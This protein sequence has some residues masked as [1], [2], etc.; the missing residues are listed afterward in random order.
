M[1]I[2]GGRKKNGMFSLNTRTAAKYYCRFFFFKTYCSGVFFLYY[3][4]CMEFIVIAGLIF[5]NGVFSMSEMAFISARQSRLADEAEKGNGFARSALDFIQNPDVFLSTIQVG[6]TL[7][8][9]IIGLYSGDV[10]ASGFSVFLKKIGVGDSFT[11]PLAQVVIVVAVTY[12]MVVFGELV[13]KRLGMSAAERISKII[14]YPMRFVLK[15][16]SP[17]V[18]ALSKSTTFFCATLGIRKPSRSITEEEIKSLIKEG[19]EGGE[20]DRIERNIVERVFNLGD[21]KLESIMTHRSDIARID[22]RMSEKEM[23]DFIHRYPYSKYPVVDGSLDR[24]L[25]F[26]H[27]KDMFNIVDDRNFD[28]RRHLKPVHYFPETMRV[29]AALE[30][31]KEKR[32]P[33]GMVCDEFGGTKGMITLKD[34]LEALVGTIPDSHEEAEFVK[35]DD[36]TFLVDGQCPFYDFL[37][38]FRKEHLYKNNQGYNTLGGLILDI[39]DRIPKTG[40]KLQWMEFGFE[41][42]DMDGARIDKVLVSPPKEELLFELDA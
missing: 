37:I 30:E 36:G 3:I 42:V 25:G 17:F 15:I 16:A 24:T 20:V 10:L 13:P 28:I 6:S 12:C 23:V 4:E 27:V 19:E 35:R 29:Y 41:I 1:F 26:V 21:K 9:I 31:I 32:L 38:F 18:W 33:Y 8:S 39:L 40:D 11:M 7:I 22:I 34:I 14:V 5:L 2:F